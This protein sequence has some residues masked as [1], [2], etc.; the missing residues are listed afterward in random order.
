MASAPTSRNP[1][2]QKDLNRLVAYWAKGPGAAKIQWGKPG[3]FARCQKQM[4]GKVPP[5]M[6]DGFCSNLHKIATGARPGKAASE[7]G[8]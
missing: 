1:A 2:H 3:D 6:I 4:V 7:K 8:A 5:Q